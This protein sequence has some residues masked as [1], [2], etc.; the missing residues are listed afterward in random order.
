[1]A[2]YQR[3]EYRIGNDGKVTETVIGAAGTGCIEVTA[4]IE[5]GLGS[6]DARELL[7]EYAESTHA[8]ATLEIDL[9][10]IQTLQQC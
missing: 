4:A 10:A 3:I 5:A 7:P 8:D 1:M 9:E 6:V 2:E